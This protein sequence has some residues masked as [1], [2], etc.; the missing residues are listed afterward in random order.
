MSI[1]TRFA[2]S[3]TGVLHI[4]GART[5]L[6]N[7]LFAKN[8]KGKFLL[9]IEDTD[10]E[11]SKK[12]YIDDILQALKW[13]E[14]NW[15]GEIVF[16][17]ERMARH[18]KVANQLIESGHAYYC[19]APPKENPKTLG[20][21]NIKNLQVFK[22]PW[23]NKHPEE[24]PKDVKPVVR[25]KVPEGQKTVFTDALKGLVEIE[26]SAIE[27]VV[28]LR[29][30]KTPTYILSAAVDDYDMGV[31]HIIRGDDHLVNTPKHIIIFNAMGWRPPHMVHIPLI[32]DD[33]GH[34][35]SKRHGAVSILEYKNLGYLPNALRN[36]ILKLGWSYKDEEILN[37]EEQIKLF[38]L[39]GLNKSQ[40][41]FDGEKLNFFNYTYINQTQD[42]ILVDEMLEIAKK[43]ALEEDKLRILKAMPEIKKRAKTLQEL[44]QKAFIYTKDMQIAP[45]PEVQNLLQSID[46]NIKSLIIELIKT[47]NIWSEESIKDNVKK[48][49]KLH[50]LNIAD[51][52]RPTRAALTGQIE[53]E[54]VFKIIEILGKE[55][56][57]QRLKKAFAL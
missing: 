33:K 41:Q 28:L 51:V 36:Y 19:F 46:Q 48:A 53:S 34:K 27:D 8:A 23:R 43:E 4:G 56:C 21:A 7:Y 25:L 55:L 40:A 2:P 32:L 42:K 1:V 9:R 12:H 10:K 26:N 16:Q 44:A 47:I 14:I 38:S 13:M 15:D 30:D 20:N 39:N 50:N 6:F 35:L 37:Y 57:L 29:Q 5:A 52:L 18:Q 11:R 24:Y 54:S 17:S 31:T 45:S 22:S 49:A 3:P